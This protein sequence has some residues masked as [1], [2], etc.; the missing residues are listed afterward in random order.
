[1]KMQRIIR[2]VWS[3]LMICF[4]LIVIQGCVN[5]RH[6]KA[7]KDYTQGWKKESVIHI[8]HMGQSLG[9]GE[10]S[11]PIVTD[12]PT[13]FRNYKFSLGTHTWSNSYFP[14]QP[15][16]RKPDGFSFVPLTAQRRGGEGE[17]IANGMADHLSYTISK[18]QTFPI[19][20]LF[21][22]SGQGGRLIR[23]LDKRHDDARDP[24]AGVRQ[25]KGGYYKT[26][27]DDIIR[28]RKSAESNG[29]LYSVGAIT[30]MQGEANGTYRLRR[31]DSV[32]DR[33]VAL[34]IYKT[35]LLNLYS[36]YLE[37][38]RTVT[39]QKNNVPFFT[40]QTA[41]SFAGIA[42]LEVS[43]K[44]N[45]LYMVGPTYMLPNAE[46]SHF[47]SK[48]Q[49]VHGDGIHLTADG[50]RWL[51]EQ[52][53]KVIRKVLFENQ[54]WQPLRPLE[55][56]VDSGG[57]IIFIRF[58]VPIPP[59]VLDTS[60]LPGQGRGY[61]FSVYD[62]QG[63]AYDIEKVTVRGKDIVAIKVKQ[64]ISK[65]DTAFVKYAQ[66]GFVSDVSQKILNVI[67]GAKN[68][69]GQEMIGVVFPGDIRKEFSVLLK[70]GVFYLSNKYVNDSSFTNLI[71][72]AVE[73]D[74]DGNTVLHGEK[75]ELRN[76]INFAPG[77]LCSLSRR[78]SYGNL[79]DS[80]TE[81]SYFSFKDST[82]G[83][84]YGEP[85]PLHNWSVAFVDFPINFV[86][87]K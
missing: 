59:L 74:R 76:S 75:S 14:D 25:S 44:G 41:G 39:G 20:F 60:F 83:K 73:L 15:E 16:L 46:N 2:W 50:E 45:G 1:M 26:S 30:W 77:Q 29:M 7:I 56:W 49:Y 40:Y 55:G 68:E 81:K 47:I 64:V 6:Y 9:A 27:I 84:R 18:R 12:S 13:G 51:G 3:I 72:R 52:F 8:I 36:D 65:P 42:Q 22:Y 80:D 5:I 62:A 66:S 11:L 53:G 43:C 69:H 58:H 31:W 78:Y 63:K 61:G 48:D 33:K 19:H 79:R 21:S 54:E 23:E 34:E 37:D 38:I 86:T 71:I 10:Q 85:Y 28:A 24:R 70:E 82:Y 35:D 32:L 67:D 17:T 4:F 57:Q 87:N